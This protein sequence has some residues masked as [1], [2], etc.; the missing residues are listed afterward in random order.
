VGHSWGKSALNHRMS[1]PSCRLSCILHEICTPH[2][3]TLMYG[4]LTLSFA[5]IDGFDACMKDGLSTHDDACLHFSRNGQVMVKKIH[6][7]EVSAG[8]RSTNEG[9]ADLDY[10]TWFSPPRH[11]EGPHKD[12][13][14]CM[15]TV[16]DEAVKKTNNGVSQGPNGSINNKI[17]LKKALKKGL[18]MKCIRRHESSGVLGYRLLG[19]YLDTVVPQSSVREVVDTNGLVANNDAKGASAPSPGTTTG[20][21]LVL[22]HDGHR[23][24]ACST[25]TLPLLPY[26]AHFWAS[27]LLT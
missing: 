16:I 4:R 8:R 7:T 2:A 27:T 12:T 11:H 21:R 26:S 20:H 6:K 14:R 24:S 19:V 22:D 5:F 15:R 18:L 9:A 13:T 10:L 17:N 1:F 23:L 25:W 3:G